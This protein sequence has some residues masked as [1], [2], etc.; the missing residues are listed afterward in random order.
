MIMDCA[1]SP[2][3]QRNLEKAWNA[4]VHRPH[5]SDPRDFRPPRAHARRRAAGRARAS[6]L[7]EEPAGALLDA[8]GA[9]A[10]RLRLPRRARAKRRSKPTGASS[11][12]ASPASS[13]ISTRSSA[14]ATLHR[15]SRKRVPYPIVAL[16]GY[17]NAGKSTLFNRLTR[18]ACCRPTCC[19]RRST[20]PCAPSTCRT[21]ARVILSDTV[22]FIS[23]LPTMLVAAFRATLGG[24]DRG[25]RDPACARHVARGCR[26]AVARRREGSGA[27]SASMP[28]RSARSIEV[29]NKI[30]RL[31][32]EAR[33]RLRQ[34]RRAAAGRSAGRCWCRR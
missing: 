5:R 26:R 32:A 27:S 17:T 13:R 7:S 4:K 11:R 29:W 22:G 16:V 9:P 34:S 2:V 15:E 30:D 28:E 24:G 6:Q 31:D 10:R 12:S 25:R 19:S 20:R 3:Q 8:S 18:R 14:R 1:V 23:D 33:A 21:A